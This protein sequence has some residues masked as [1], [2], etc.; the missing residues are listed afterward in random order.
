M[1]QRSNKK[2]K[3]NG[4]DVTVIY[5]WNCRGIRNKEAEL[6]LHVD[7]L[8]HKPDVIALQ[9]TNGKPR[10]PG[11]VTYTDPTEEGTAVLVRSNVAAT[12]HVTP[13][14]GCEHTLVEI[15]ART[16]GNTGNLYVMSAYC[17]PSQR[18]YDLI[19]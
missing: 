18:Q 10:L 6:L 19:E 11:Y 13:Q 17:R 8:E 7:A 15:H 1:K 14:G 16:I 12:Q 2:K 5:Q 9:E 4:E 3:T